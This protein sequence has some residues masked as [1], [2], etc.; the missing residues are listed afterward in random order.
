MVHKH[1]LEKLHQHL[2]QLILRLRIIYLGHHNNRKFLKEINLVYSKINRR[3]KVQCLA[4][5][6]Q[7]HLQE[8]HQRH[9]VN[10]NKMLDLAL[11]LQ[12]NKLNLNRMF[13]EINLVV[14]RRLPDFRLKHQN[15]IKLQA[16]QF[17]LRFLVNHQF[18]PLA[19]QSNN[20][21]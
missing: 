16:F 18:Q 14:C 8:E 9:L 19:I 6:L 5:A 10:L 7:V 1:Y 21:K 20:H 3:H 4:K 15:K 17:S 2:D 13:L 11:F 12:I